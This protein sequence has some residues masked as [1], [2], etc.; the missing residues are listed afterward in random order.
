MRQFS[1]QGREI[2]INSSLSALFLKVFHDLASERVDEAMRIN[3]ATTCVRICEH[4]QAL[5]A[6]LR[7]TVAAAHFVALH[8]LRFLSIKVL[9][10][11]RHATGRTLLRTCLLHPLLEALLCLLFLLRSFRVGSQL[12]GVFLTGEAP[13]KGLSAALQAGVLLANRALEPRVVT[14]LQRNAHRAI[15]S[16]ARPDVRSGGDRLL[17]AA[18]QQAIDGLRREKLPQVP[19]G[20]L[21]GA[22][23]AGDGGRSVLQ[24]SLRMTQHALSTVPA[25]P[26]AQAHRAPWQGV[27][28]ADLA[29]VRVAVQYH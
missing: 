26:A 14:V 2:A 24:A 12:L 15:R 22:L 8:V 9:L 3:G 23:R 19:L 10:A 29:H 13:V 6:E 20:Q 18:R 28:A 5:E 25:M 1:Y 21:L 27:A 17:Q 7:S 4:R 11:H 16:G